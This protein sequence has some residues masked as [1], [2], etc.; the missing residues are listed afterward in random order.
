MKRSELF[1]FY[2]KMQGLRYHSDSKKFSYTLIKNIKA[3]EEDIKKLNEIIKPDD[4]FMKF[5]KERISICEKHALKDENGEP[6]KEGDEFKIGNMATFSE[7]LK[8]IKEKYSGIL[9]KRQEQINKYNS[10]LDDDVYLE[11]LKI[12][13]DDLPENITPNEIEDIYYMLD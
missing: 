10:M 9:L 7:E 11:I 2:N 13:P 12:G 3:I 8:P 1:D 4:E 6:L 5:E